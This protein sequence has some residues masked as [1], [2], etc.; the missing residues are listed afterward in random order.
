MNSPILTLGTGTPTARAESGV[1]A[2]GEDPVAD[3]G[4]QQDP[5][6]RWRRTRSHHST[7]ILTVM[8]PSG[9]SEA[10]SAWAAMNPSRPETLA[11]ATVPVISL[12]TP[13]LMTRSMKNVHRVIRK[14]GIPVLHHQVAVDEPDAQR[15]Q[16]AD[17]HPDPHVQAELVGDQHRREQRGGHHRDTR[18][19][20]RTRRRSSAGPPRRRRSRWSSEAYRTVANAGSVRNAGAIAKKKMKIDDRRGHGADLRTGQH[21]GEQRPLDRRHHCAAQTLGGWRGRRRS[22]RAHD[23]A[24]EWRGS[25]GRRRAGWCRGAPASGSQT[26]GTRRREPQCRLPRAVRASAVLFL[27]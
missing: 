3:L 9:M 26:G 27:A 7:V 6:R 25:D 23:L 15:E 10:K 2:D 14:L 22:G 18:R 8:N 20:G 5:R 24:P 4:A 17:Q 11:V 19:T 16:Q 1:A 12:V 21:A 13:R